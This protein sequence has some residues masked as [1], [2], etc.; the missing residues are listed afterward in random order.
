FTPGVYRV[1]NYAGTLT[2][3][4]LS[5]GT[6]PTTN[7]ADYSV[8]TSVANQV[9][10]IYTAGLK[11]SYWDGDPSSPGGNIGVANDGTIQ[12]GNGTWNASNND[13]TNDTGTLNGAYD[14][15]S[16]AV[17][18]GA[19]GIVT[20]DN[21]DGQIISGGMSFGTSGYIINGDQIELAPGSD[22]IQ[23]GDG[24]TAGGGYT[25]TISS[26]LTGTGGIN[27]TDAGT[28]VLS[29]N[30]SYAGGTTISGGTLQLGNGGTSGSIVGDVTDNG[31]LAFNRSDTATF[32]GNITGTG[33]VNQN[34]VGTT[35]LTGQTLWTGGTTINAG[36]LTLDGSNGGAQLTGTITGQTGTTL[37]IN[38]GATWNLTG[39]STVGNL[40]GNNGNIAM[41]TNLAAGIGD[42]IAA[43]TANGNI[44]ITVSNT[45][46][47]ITGKAPIVELIDV[48][49]PSASSGNYTLSNGPIPVG[50]YNYNLLSGKQLNY[51]QANSAN[52]YLAPSYGKEL[53]TLV[54]ASDQT[55]T[56]LMANDSL[57]QRM[58]E[59]RTSS[60]DEQKH[61]YQTW[62]R[63][64]GW[65][66]N[67]NTDNSQIS[68]KENTYG[69]DLGADKTYNTRI[70][71]IYTGIMVGYGNSRRSMNSG[72]GQSLTDTV[73]GGIYGTWINSKGYYIDALAKLGNIHNNI[74][75]Y[76]TENSRADYSNW[77]ITASLEAGKQFKTETGWYIEPQAQITILNFTGSNFA[78]SGN[79]ASIEQRN[80]TSYDLRAGIVA[81]KNIK[82][83]RGSI[84]PYL[85]GMYGRSWTDQG[86]ISY[87]GDTIVANT[88]GDRYQVGG[89]VAWQIT[90]S[91]EVHA[92][93][94]YIK[95]SRIEVP[96]KFNAGLRYNW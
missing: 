29:G 84:Q 92:D 55:G 34:G 64:Y 37:N 57:L 53:T 88:S 28:L 9:N 16:F 48:A 38:N 87:N 36:T 27:K 89:G 49:N 80:S 61:S 45:G 40:N 10:L 68:Y 31:T 50:L 94:E 3:T 72:A 21:S 73:Y 74:K 56:W 35:V 91:T 77:G 75:A 26:E 95:G 85:K 44:A 1:I 39:N 25:A 32:T 96:W 19:P 76:D 11:F 17:F 13:W 60:A 66:A 7:T 14:N 30:N 47:T 8:Q 4:G 93:Y 79:Q 15:P 54:G 52:W 42:Q 6:L 58:G 5:L 70:G 81:G 62:I 65:Q 78:T 2:G 59:L 18:Q 83:E 86:G 24:T 63:G 41:N 46:G 43:D 20:V 33:T 69:L 22:T 90:Q 71:K 23:V 82:T 12:G 67:I 51:G